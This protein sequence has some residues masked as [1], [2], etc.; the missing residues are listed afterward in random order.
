MDSLSFPH[1]P[2]NKSFQIASNQLPFPQALSLAPIDSV[3]SPR[4][5]NCG[6]KVETQILLLILLLPEESEAKASML[7][8]IKF[9]TY[10][11][12][13]RPANTFSFSSLFPLKVVFQQL[14]FLPPLCKQRP[15]FHFFSSV[16]SYFNVIFLFEMVPEI[17]VLHVGPCILRIDRFVSIV[18]E[19][20]SQKN[21]P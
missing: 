17:G 9:P 18:N 5:Y 13:H 21:E 15:C 11:G 3:F 12:L 16:F 10:Y 14:T 4:A 2:A 7:L 8:L 20:F 6:E 1:L 19:Y